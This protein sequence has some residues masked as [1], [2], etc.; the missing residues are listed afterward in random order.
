MKWNKD[1]NKDE[2]F[3][4]LDKISIYKN[5]ASQVVTTYNGHAINIANVSNRYEIFDIITYLKNK[6]E[7]IEKNF[8]ISKYNLILHRGIQA[9][10]LTSDQVDINGVKF[11]KSFYILNST[12]KSRR[13]SFNSGLHSVSGRF[14]VIDARNIGLSKLHLTGVTKAAEDETAKIN[15]ETFNEQIESIN[16]L[17]GHRILFSKIRE[18][19]LGEDEDIPKINHKKFDSFKNSIR[20]NKSLLIPGIKLTAEQA[21]QLYI[22]S[23][24]L[25][26]IKH[27]FY[28]DAFGAF[29]VYLQIFYN[30][31]S[32]IIKK[33]TA[34]I[35]KITQWSIRN[36]KLEELGII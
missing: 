5:D 17:V 35:M 3:E 33:E 8:N 25:P 2:I 14:H 24:D 31:D 28:I 20:Y 6:I 18:V 36:D 15:D 10:E 29:Q 16:S 12:D 19:I 13:L 26:E 22:S 21:N 30:Q 4:V 7:L 27:D 11:Y 32:Q 1:Y 9:I 34:N 23:I